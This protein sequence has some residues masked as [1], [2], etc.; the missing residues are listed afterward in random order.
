[1]SR[2]VGVWSVVDRELVVS[3]FA[4]SGPL[5]RKDLEREAAHVAHA[6]GAGTL[7]L[8]GA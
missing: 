8:R 4:G 5:P 3:A 6:S 1:M 2:V 7:T